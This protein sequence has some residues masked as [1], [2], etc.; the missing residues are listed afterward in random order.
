MVV[1]NCSSYEDDTVYTNYTCKSYDEQSCDIFC[2]SGSKC[3]DYCG[4]DCKYGGGAVCAASLLS[5]LDCGD[6][7]DATEEEDEEAAVV[8]ATS[9]GCDSHVYCDFCTNSD[10]RKLLNAGDT[11]YASM[12]TPSQSK[13]LKSIT[14][15]GGNVYGPKALV[16]TNQLS[17]VCKWLNHHRTSATATTTDLASVTAAFEASSMA[18]LGA[19]AALSVFVVA[20]LGYVRRKAKGPYAPLA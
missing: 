5:S 15:D 19:F 6:Y 12:L 17:N 20:L 2:A 11:A 9:D 16:L 3:Y 1:S 4:T 7:G 8:N 10:C 13:S 14:T 18:P